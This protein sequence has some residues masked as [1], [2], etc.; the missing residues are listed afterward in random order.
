MLLSFVANESIQTG[1][2]VSVL[3][4]PLGR[5]RNIDPLSFASARSVGIAVD[6]VASGGLCRVISRGEANFFSSLDI[7]STYYAPLSGTTPV[8]YSG[9]VDVFNTIEA[10]GAYLCTLGT[11]I[12]A[13][14]LSIN[15]DTPVLVQKDSLD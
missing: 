5:I 8:V 1:A 6:T 3:D 13:T 15:L 14:T 11:A 7:G 12:S 2:P 4:S 10:S 9:F